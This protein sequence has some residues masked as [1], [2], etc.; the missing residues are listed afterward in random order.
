ML[1]NLLRRFLGRYRTWL[2][3]VVVCQAVQSFA[4]LTL[5]SINADIIDNGVRSGDTGYIW[6]HGGLMLLVSV[7]QKIGRAHV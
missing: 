1:I 2:V 3:L 4:S 7:V 5:P 6:R